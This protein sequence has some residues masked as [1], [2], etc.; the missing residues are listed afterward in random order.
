M[1]CIKDKASGVIVG[2]DEEPAQ[3]FEDFKSTQNLPHYLILMDSVEANVIYDQLR[4]LAQNEITK[5][6]I[7]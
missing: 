6:T 1:R 2:W 5:R 7:S 3:D 4:Y